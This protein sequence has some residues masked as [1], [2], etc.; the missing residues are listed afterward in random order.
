METKRYW[1]LRV[2]PDGLFD[3][4]YIELFKEQTGYE[5]A[6]LARNLARKLALK[7]PGETFLVVKKMLEYRVEETE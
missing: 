5:R 6:S 2:C 4:P 1:V 3:T 7:Y